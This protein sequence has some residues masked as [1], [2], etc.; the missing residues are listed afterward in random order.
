MIDVTN[1][2]DPLNLR[3]R[4]KVVLEKDNKKLLIGNL[5]NFVPR[6]PEDQTNQRGFLKIIEDKSLEVPWMMKYEA[7]EP[8]LV[9]SGKKNVYSVLKDQSYMFI[10]EFCLKLYG[11]FVFGPRKIGIERTPSY[12]QNGKS[13]L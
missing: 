2:T 11:K 8:T 12:L 6:V 13:Y 10:P 1:M 5:D 3:L 4:L 7:G 9:L